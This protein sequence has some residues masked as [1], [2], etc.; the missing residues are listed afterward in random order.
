MPFI[1]LESKIKIEQNK[2]IIVYNPIWPSSV[3]L[4]KLDQTKLDEFHD[5]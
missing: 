2:W 3:I 1:N 4:N 5:Q